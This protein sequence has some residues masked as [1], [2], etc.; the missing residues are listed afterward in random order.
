[1]SWFA[2]FVELEN[3]KIPFQL[4]LDSLD[5]DS[6]I[7]IVAAIDELIEWK[8][9]QLQLPESKS[10]YLRNKIFEMKVRH[11]TIIT[12]SLYFFVEGKKIIFTHGFIKKTQRTPNSEIEMAEKL[13]NIYLSLRNIK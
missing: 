3:G 13:R 12:R 5:N 1:M 11:K 6:K 7:N 9:L 2:E 4:F 8:N 10:K